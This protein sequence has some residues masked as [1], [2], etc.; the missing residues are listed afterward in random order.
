MNCRVLR[1]RV[2]QT[3][4]TRSPAIQGRHRQRHWAVYQHNQIASQ[5]HP[6]RATVQCNGFRQTFETEGA[7]AP[8][9]ALTC[10]AHRVV[11]VIA[12]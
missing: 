10:S 6:L 5:R 1:V 2:L 4:A 12:S 3:A 7:R 9:L 11:L 8:A